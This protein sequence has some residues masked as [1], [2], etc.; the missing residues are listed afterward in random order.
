MQNPKKVSDI[1]VG[2]AQNA[3]IEM[4]NKK[5]AKKGPNFHRSCQNMGHKFALTSLAF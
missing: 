2:E 3:A 1:T 5:S 4:K